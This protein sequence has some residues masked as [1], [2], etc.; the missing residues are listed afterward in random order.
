MYPYKAYDKRNETERNEILYAFDHFSH[1]G[2]SIV[3]LFDTEF[4]G[5]DFL[6]FISNSDNGTFYAVLNKRKS[7]FELRNN[8]SNMIASSQPVAKATRATCRYGKDRDITFETYDGNHL[9]L[10]TL[11]HGSLMIT[12]EY[13]TSFNGN[14]DL[15][16]NL[17]T[18]MDNSPQG[19]L[20]DCFVVA[21]SK[22]YFVDPYNKKTEFLKDLQ[23]PAGY[24]YL[25]YVRSDGISTIL[26]SQDFTYV[27]VPYKFFY[28]KSFSDL[29]DGYPDKNSS[30][31]DTHGQYL[32]AGSSTLKPTE[33]K[34][35]LFSKTDV[36]SLDTSGID[37][38]VDEAHVTYEDGRLTI[39]FMNKTSIYRWQ[40]SQ[41]GISNLKLRKLD[42]KP[43]PIKP[44]K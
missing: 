42:I 10:F 32:V 17:L 20:S 21:G 38:P 35:F 7:R 12:P 16:I 15:N 29:P 6:G 24:G 27:N 2:L 8:S 22:L 33:T 30:Y 39:Y 37:E 26:E 31:Y 11:S 13:E 5:I 25:Y 9:C 4:D 3:K 18:K 28:Q 34:I 14:T 23:I 1:P 36:Y 44:I 19:Y 40:N 41:E 43:E